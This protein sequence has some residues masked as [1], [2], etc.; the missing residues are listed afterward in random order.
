[1]S[2]LRALLL[3]DIVDSTQMSEGLGDDAMVAVWAAHDRVARDLLPDRRGREIDKTDGMLLLFDAVE[4]AVRYALDYQRAL[5]A[6]PVPV[7]ARA[8]LHF[9]PVVL[10]ENR[11]DDIARG[12]K[13]LEVDGLAKPITARVMSLAR[14]GQLL[15]TAE[16]ISE[17]GKTDMPIQSHG[18][19]I[20]K[21]VSE[22]VELFEVR[23]ID[24][25]FA[26]PEDGEKAY[27][28]IR[29]GERWLPV[30]EIPNN[31][32]QSST[33]FVG[34]DREL[35]ELKTELAKRRLITLLGM[36][37]L[38]KTRLSLQLAAEV[39][40][41]FPDGVWFID[42]S[43]LRDPALVVSETAQV[44]GVR[45]EPS[46]PLIE[47]LCAHLKPRRVLLVADNCEH[48]TH[49]AASLIDALLRAAP[50]VRIVASSREILRV[51]GELGYP[52]LPLPVPER[53]AD[54]Q[55]L[56]QSAAVRL[57]VER[58]QQHKP[59]FALTEREAPA[60]AELVARLEGIP[61]ALEL[62]AARVRSL[63]VGDINLRLRDRYKL[64]TGG[65][66]TL[67]QRQQTLRALVDWS[68]DLLSEAERTTLRRLGVFVGGFD[69]TAAEHVCG[70][71]PLE[72]NDLLDLVAS[73][74]DKSLAMVEEGTQGTRYRMLETIREYALERLEQAGERAATAA[75]HCEYFF[76]L[77]KQGRDGLRAADQALWIDR[78]ETDLDNLRTAISLAIAGGADQLVAVKMAV[79][80]Q[81]FWLLRGYATEGRAIVRDALLLPAVQASDRAQAWALYVGAAL[82]V[83][84]ADYANARQMLQTCL[85]LRRQLG[86]PV[87]IAATLSTLSQAMLHG[88]D[89]TGAAELEREG[90][91]IFRTL[92]DR[93]GEAIGLLHLGE[94]ALALDDAEAASAHLL[95]ALDIARQ[96][97]HRET[98]AACEQMLGEIELR[99][100]NLSQ[101]RARFNRSLSTCRD[102]AEKLGEAIALRWLGNADLAEGDFDSAHR[103]LAEALTSFKAFEM[104]GELL[105]CLE[106]LAR[107]A[108]GTG[109]PQQAVRLAAAV[110]AMR[111]RMA[112][113]RLP[114]HSKSWHAWFD[115]LRDSMPSGDFD[116]ASA[117][118]GQWEVDEAI[119]NAMKSEPT[120]FSA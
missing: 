49:A 79:A 22:P 59:S 109:A 5:A 54:V 118:G 94:C 24:T 37:G 80:L 119:R 81:D 66:R 58:A 117:N 13:P 105:G 95:Q 93:R 3:T 75:R 18:H 40:H 90:L 101:A 97:R 85:A 74:T 61:L 56:L 28:V 99:R 26:A 8:G 46:R 88:G 10:R 47:T 39:R 120:P 69:L 113:G 55:T 108:R 115:A 100:G 70:V 87:D 1:M 71:E 57:F 41:K 112:I 91:Q 6:L 84:Q 15:L 21:G 43:P 76:A 72:S 9:G 62:A 4:D 44:L 19:W 48:L 23:E 53:S 36:G 78:L 33:T 31:L 98:D 17:L 16:A 102:A 12:A 110:E 50:D 2:D 67:Q 35:R 64:L 92:G 38:G 32:P 30:R 7:S 86:P 83:S 104:W 27:R 106:D 73:L 77:A 11:A 29:Q 25:R 42:L 20:L 65:G 103:R 63:G 51:P 34:R 68:H 52:V 107:L 114:L 14:G 111:A 89:I 96:I 82:A 116:R 45:D 60:V